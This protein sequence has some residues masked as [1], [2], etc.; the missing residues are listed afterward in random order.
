MAH[1]K[2]KVTA[3]GQGG[4]NLYSPAVLYRPATNALLERHELCVPDTTAEMLANTIRKSTLLGPRRARKGDS[5][6]TPRERLRQA[7]QAAQRLLSYATERVSHS[8]SIATQW[9]KLHDAI[10]HPTM[11]VWIPVSV[12][13]IPQLLKKLSPLLDVKVAGAAKPLLQTVTA[14][15]TALVH[16]VAENEK[17]RGSTTGR[18]K[19]W[20]G[21][22]IRGGC[23]AWHRSGRDAEFAA[24]KG[25]SGQRQ[26]ARAE[27]LGNFIRDLLAMC[28]ITLG[29]DALR[30]AV[31][32]AWSDVRRLLATPVVGQPSQDAPKLGVA[33]TG[34]FPHS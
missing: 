13:N 14:E 25:T 33:K 17:Q 18:P 5:D 19:D 34:D 23:I 32:S 20:P 28:G 22:V 2:P 11:F 21:T 29:D 15:L 9:K 3:G 10:N 12:S 26:R 31:S 4:V 24:Q 27:A 16:F 1:R 7:R 8:T 6:P 30:T